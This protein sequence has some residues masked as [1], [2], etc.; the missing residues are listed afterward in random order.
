MTVGSSSRQID[1]ERLRVEQY[2][3]LR[4]EAM[5]LA[6]ATRRVETYVIGATAALYAYLTEHPLGDKW[7]VLF[8]PVP[9]I[10]FG[11]WRSVR[12]FG[13]RDDLYRDIHDIEDQ[14]G[15]ERREKQ[16]GIKDR[17]KETGIPPRENEGHKWTA[18][19]LWAMLLILS[20]IAPF[21][22]R[23]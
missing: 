12:L 22:L 11:I 18:I 4:K 20:L 6:T 9:L 14:A 3:S 16:A 1:Y 10:L 15:V 5:D 13:M 19:I 21:F 8:L 17:E 7:W 2:K 23:S